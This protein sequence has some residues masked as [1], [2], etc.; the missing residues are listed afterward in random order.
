[1]LAKSQKTK[2]NI[3]VSMIDMGSALAPNTPA[4]RKR[5]HLQIVASYFWLVTHEDTPAPCQICPRTKRLV[6]YTTLHAT[7]LI[8]KPGVRVCYKC[9]GDLSLARENGW[10]DAEKRLFSGRV[11]ATRKSANSESVGSKPKQNSS[12]SASKP[13]RRGRTTS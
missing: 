13:T 10:K 11:R 4:R 7:H 1:M 12:S 6:T 3:S 2:D 5:R 8:E 9:L